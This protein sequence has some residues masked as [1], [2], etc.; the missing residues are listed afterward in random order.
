MHR[1]ANIGFLADIN[2]YMCKYYINAS[3]R[4]HKFDVG[5]R[6]TNENI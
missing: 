4:R 2:G 6:K 3:P 1:N 5:R